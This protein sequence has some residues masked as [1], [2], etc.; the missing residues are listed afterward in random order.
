[1]NNNIKKK[2]QKVAEALRR[3]S[4]WFDELFVIKTA[5]STQR[6][7]SLNKKKTSNE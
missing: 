2:L 5:R 3:K 6:A 4:F 1:M 7:F